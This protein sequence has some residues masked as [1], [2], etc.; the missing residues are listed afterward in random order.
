MGG[1][2]VV[3][4]HS[5]DGDQV[6]D[7]AIGEVARPIHQELGTMGGSDAGSEGESESVA[8]PRRSQRRT[9]GTIPCRSRSDYVLK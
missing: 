3:G 8:E 6:D 5:S 7:E 1:R 2:E 9:R 4:E